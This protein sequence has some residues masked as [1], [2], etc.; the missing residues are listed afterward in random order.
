MTRQEA[1]KHFGWGLTEFERAEIE[2]YSE[3][4][5]LGLAV[6]KIHGEEGAAQNNGYDDENGNYN[7][8]LHDHI[9]YRYEILEV[10]GKGSFGQ[11]IRAWDHK[12]AQYI[13][14]KI[15]R[16]KK[17]FHHQALIEVQI[18]EHLRKKDV[19]ANH[20]V[21]HMLEY[22]YFRNHLCITFELMRYVVP[23]TTF[24]FSSPPDAF[25]LETP[26]ALNKLEIQ[27]ILR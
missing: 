1:I 15:I 2:Q 3:I 18:L 21:I 7:K 16:N 14:I 22:F 5:Y 19:D 25:G 26:R 27:V 24:Y 6:H 20:N 12:T 10:I 17:R 11:V 9:S 8:V 13:A 4:W 23:G